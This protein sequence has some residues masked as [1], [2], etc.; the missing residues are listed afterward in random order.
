MDEGTSATTW[1]KVSHE[2][3]KCRIDIYRS[4]DFIEVLCTTRILTPNAYNCI[5]L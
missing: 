2:I 1:H 3:M 4:M 5:G